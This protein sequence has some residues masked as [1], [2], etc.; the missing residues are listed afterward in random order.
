V[1][2]AIPKPSLEIEIINPN[3]TQVWAAEV[4][5]LMASGRPVA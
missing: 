4:E 2:V 5:E 1:S 3:G